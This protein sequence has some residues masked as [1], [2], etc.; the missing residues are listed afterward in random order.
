MKQTW[1]TPR[2]NIQNF[3]A[4][5]YVAA[6]WGVG[7]S[8]DAANSVEKGKPNTNPYKWARNNYEGGQTH[9]WDGCGTSSNQFLRDTTGDN[10]F[11]V[12]QEYKSVP[13]NG[14][15]WLTCTVY[16][17]GSYNSEKSLSDVVVGE[18]IYWTTSATDGRIW[19]HQGTVQAQDTA[20]PN[21]S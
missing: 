7:C 6:C 1:V 18:Y 3:E 12:M 16:T 5:E 14:S 11:D 19:Y 8:V 9:A 21:R 4:N 2:V 17:D 10:I 15:N 13:V 20:H